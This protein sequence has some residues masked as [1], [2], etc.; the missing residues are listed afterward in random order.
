MQ[1]LIEKSLQK[2][3]FTTEEAILFIE[4]IDKELLTDAQI[5][6]LLMSVELRGLQLQELIGFR[7]ALLSLAKPV[8]LDP[9]AI[10]LCGTGGDG[11][12]TFNI[13]STTALVMAAMGYKI[14]KHGN[15]GVSS[16]CGSSQ[17][18]EALG[19]DLSADNKKLESDLK[20]RNIAILHAPH[21]H[22]TLKKV[23]T[24]RKQLGFKTLFNAVGPLVNPCQPYYQVTG[25]FS[26]SLAQLYQHVLR[27]HRTSFKVIHGMDGYDELTL[28]HQTRV[29]CQKAEKTQNAAAFGTTP[30]ESE[31]LKN[32]TSVA[33]AA[34]L[35]R[36]I[37]NGKGTVA[38]NSVV[39]ANVAT[40]IHCRDQ[41]IQL[42]EA[43]EEAISFIQSGATGKHFQF[44]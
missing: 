20:N 31:S 5:A 18:F 26:I 41:T 6:A 37:C 13:S 29:L 39:A 14:I 32:A 1:I 24:I 43:F 44:N 35:V 33:L 19:F 9:D 15:Y 27:D 11:K 10:D 3:P 36:N 40:A 21:F 30:I 22:P 16:H 12:N 23:A 25:T 8:D 38:Q 4:A 42:P 7:K 17:V 28:T 2:R 34:Q